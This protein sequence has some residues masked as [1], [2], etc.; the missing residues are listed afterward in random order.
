MLESS[1]L[2]PHGV[3]SANTYH[4]GQFDECIGLDVPKYK[5]RGKYCLPK[6]Q[7]GP[8]KH[9]YPDFYLDTFHFDPHGLYY[10][11][12]LPVWDKIKVT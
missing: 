5:L 6:I 10:N 3:L 4:L 2:A 11:P 7:F 9:A 12:E 8:D 1:A